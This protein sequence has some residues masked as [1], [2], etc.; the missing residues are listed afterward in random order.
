[1]SWEFMQSVFLVAGGLGLFLFGMKMMSGGL[2]A[3]AGD[4]LHAILKK[5]TS[6]RFLAVFVGIVA[7]IAINSSTA[8]TIMTVGFV[9]SGLLNLIQSIGIIMGANVGTTFSAQLIAF[10]IDTIAP[11]FIFIGVIMYLF[12]KRKGV[13]NLGY[14]ILGFGVLFFG[15]TV[16]GEPLKEFAQTPSFNQMLTTFSNPIM[17]LLAGF[18]FTAIIQSSSATMGIL[19]TMHLNGVP[20]PFET[21]AFIILGTNIGTS[22]TTVIASIPASRESKRA[23]LFHIMYDIIGSIVFG[24]LIFLFPAILNW[25]TSTWD[26][27][28]RQVAMFHTLYNVATC[29]LLIGFVKHIARL[30]EKIVPEEKK[31]E[32]EEPKKL[33]YLDENITKAPATGI[34]QARKEL[35]RLGQMTSANFKLAIESFYER[36]EQKANQV[37]EKEEIINYIY[38]QITIWLV[39]I[40][41][42]NI[43]M[44]DRKALSGMFKLVSDIERI[45]D[46]A[47]NIAGYTIIRERFNVK[48]SDGA[49]RELKNM[50]N[51]VVR[52]IDLSVECVTHND[53]TNQN[54]IDKMEKEVDKLA[55]LNVEN[56]I[57]RLEAKICDPRSGVVYTDII[58]DLERS[59]DHAMNITNQIN[60]TVSQDTKDLQLTSITK[61]KIKKLPK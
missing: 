60:Y 21:S 24:T 54:I 5:A 22:I 53:N 4:R 43:S 41:D 2:E 58:T 55:I 36:D 1:M 25:F 20:I 17:A 12:F 10:K 59:A 11:L 39:K 16:M 29:I 49:T 38:R 40:Q 37:L 45:G 3:I 34:I 33:L 15:V 13:K 52:I 51:M 32:G 18:L 30:M 47:K 8:V 9:N 35:A 27:P 23:A 46:H 6:N 31:V 7:T 61:R 44:T 26:H 50:S 14:V 57:A 56:H 28:A 48:F 19:V 42:L